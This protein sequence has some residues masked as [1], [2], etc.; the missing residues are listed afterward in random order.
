VVPCVQVPSVVLV[1]ELVA[2]V[3]LVLVLVEEELLLE[4]VVL[5]LEEL[6]VGRVEELVE[7]V[8]L[9]ERSVEVDA[10]VVDVVTEVV[11]ELVVDEEL[12]EVEV[13]LVVVVVVVLVETAVVVED[14]LVEVVL[15]VL[16]PGAD[17]RSTWIRP[18]RMW[19]A[20]KLPVRFAPSTMRSVDPGAQR[21]A[22]ILE[23]RPNV[24]CVPPTKR[25]RSRAARPDAT[26]MVARW[27]MARLPSTSTRVGAS[28]SSAA[29][30]AARRPQMT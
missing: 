2:V 4:L 10:T 3:A 15:V 11:E 19:P 9:E 20:M 1:L 30:R 13:V 8:E 27:P 25:V 26:S 16:P 24:T 21:C 28:I 29:S 6:V 17:P 23:T 22:R 5:E 18:D 14:V 12:K 7:V